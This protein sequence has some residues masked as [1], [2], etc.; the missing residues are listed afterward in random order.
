MSR[1]SH[2]KRMSILDCHG[3]VS[4]EFVLLLNGDVRVL[5]YG[6][7]FVVHV[8]SG[9][10]TPPSSRLERDIVNRAIEFANIGF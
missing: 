7:E 4:E 6:R 3:H 1:D 9:L 10:V 2:L 8:D 5:K